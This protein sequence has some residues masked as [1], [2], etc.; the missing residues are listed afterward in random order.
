[1]NRVAASQTVRVI[2]ADDHDLV[3]SGIKVLLTM[4]RG[5]EVVAEAC[6]GQRLIDL[7][8]SLNPDV[9][10]TDISMPVM[11][12]ITAMAHLHRTRPGVRLLALSMHDSADFVQRA[13]ASGACGYLL[14]DAPPAELE[15]ALRQVMTSGHYFSPAVTQRMLQPAEP[16]ADDELTPR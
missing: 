11:D 12:G 10:M 15:Q 3:R 2:L 14:K 5:V 1:M 9:V 16:T 8:E 7:A 4:I 6:N 13:V